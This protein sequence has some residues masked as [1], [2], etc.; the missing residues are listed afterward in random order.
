M[1][2]PGVGTGVW[3]RKDGKVLLGLRSGKYL[4]GT[5]CIPGGKLEMY[6]EWDDG[7]RREALEETG[8]E[9]GE[10]RLAAILDDRNPDAGTH[11][12]SMHFVADWREGEPVPELGKFE[13]WGWF[14]L[15]ELPEPLFPATRN[16]I[17]KGYNPFTI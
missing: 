2:Y 14:G 10:M 12:I 13:T 17:D 16:F 5:W 9:I 3:I 6:E 11:Y 8:V 15:D 1:E 4:P 7:A